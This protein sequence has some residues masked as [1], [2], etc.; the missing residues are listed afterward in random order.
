M[1]ALSFT[2]L[3]KRHWPVLTAIL[4]FLQLAIATTLSVKQHWREAAVILTVLGTLLLVAFNLWVV[5][6]RLS[7]VL[8]TDTVVRRFSRRARVR[9]HAGSAVLLTGCWTVLWFVNSHWALGSFFF[10][11]GNCE[12]ARPHL[13]AVR[14]AKRAGYS[15]LKKLAECYERAGDVRQF[16]DA[17]EEALKNPQILASIS[18]SDRVTLHMQAAT[19]LLQDDYVPDVRDRGSKARWH[20][21]EARMLA[22]ERADVPL[23]M[24]MTIAGDPAKHD[25]AVRLLELADDGRRTDPRARTGA[26]LAA[27][28]YLRGRVWLA[29][30]RWEEARKD[31]SSGLEIAAKLPGGEPILTDPFL[32]RLG[33]IEMCRSGKYDVEAALPYWNRISSRFSK[34]RSLT[35]SALG[36]WAECVIAREA[37]D[38]ETAKRKL[39]EAENYL[40]VAHRQGARDWRLSVTLGIMYFERRDYE[41]A[42]GH[43]AEATQVDP[44]RQLAFKMLG[45]ARFNQGGHLAEARDALSRAVSLDDTDPRAHYWLGKVLLQMGDKNQATREYERSLAIGKEE[46]PEIQADLLNELANLYADRGEH[47]DLAVDYA[48]QAVSSEG[49]NPWYQDTLGWALIRSAERTGIQ[50]SARELAEAER[51]LRQAAKD[52][53]VF[54][55]L[56]LAVPEVKAHMLYHLGYLEK[57]RGAP[58]RAR[59]YFREALRVDPNHAEAKLELK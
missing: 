14:R 18:R 58:A 45:R 36:R 5:F 40:R 19:R 42:A 43:F 21:K 53:D 49:R 56:G 51:L 32:Y 37:G 20:L 44:G 39:A 31:F 12:Q 10:W 3:V 55:A 17:I 26:F 8:R 27:Y 29:M 28:H 4:S 38:R 15:E 16:L 30:D 23:W 33:E 13:E 52:I 25:D 35:L 50:A 1:P 48:R 24:A 6:A 41:Q 47:V 59:Q 11:I 7:S 57:L 2:A 46:A 54:A 34:L 9:I 22:P